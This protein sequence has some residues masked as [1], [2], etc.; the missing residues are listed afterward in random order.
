MTSELAF[1]SAQFTGL[2]IGSSNIISITMGNDVNES[3]PSPELVLKAIASLAARVTQL[4]KASVPTGK[5]SRIV[6]TTANFNKILDFL[7]TYGSFTKW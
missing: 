5:F 2:L 3:V 7:E 6:L 1:F 4:E